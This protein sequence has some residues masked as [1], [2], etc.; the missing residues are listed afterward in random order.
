[1]RPILRL[2]AFTLVFSC[3]RG[4]F[5]Q[6]ELLNTMGAKHTLSIDQVAGFRI[7]SSGLSYA[8]P[9]GFS[10]RSDTATSF[11]NNGGD[12]TLKTY[13]VAVGQDSWRVAHGPTNRPWLVA[14]TT[15]SPLCF[16]YN[17]ARDR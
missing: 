12:S 15:N 14:L 13:A 3:A 5:A 8:G 10:T 9:I 6:R 11:Q 17:L 4:A 2:L 7:N 16:P 1:M